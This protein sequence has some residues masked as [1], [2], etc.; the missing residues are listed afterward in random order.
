MCTLALNVRASICQMSSK[1]LPNVS[2][3]DLNAW[4]LLRT[5]SV[6]GQWRYWLCTLA[7]SLRAHRIIHRIIAPQTAV[8]YTRS[9][10]SVLLDHLE[11]ALLVSGYYGGLIFSRTLALCW[12][13]QSEEHLLFL[14]RGIW[15][16]LR[17]G[18]QVLPF[19]KST[20]AFSSP[21]LGLHEYC[22]AQPQ[23]QLDWA[24]LIPHYTPTNQPTTNN[25]PE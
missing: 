4:L 12:S 23:P 24:G 6:H 9:S 11:R 16:E 17:F 7:L 20:Q 10:V 3:T 14:E 18:L 13:K 15:R 22:Q 25:H 19:K 2:Q 1:C 21:L 8:L 5:K